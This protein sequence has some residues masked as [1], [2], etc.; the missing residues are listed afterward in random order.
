MN[1]ERILTEEE[2]YS[3]IRL[4]KEEENVSLQIKKSEY[5]KKA[6]IIKSKFDIRKENIELKIKH[7]KAFDKFEKEIKKYSCMSLTK[8]F[9][10]RDIQFSS[11]G[12][13]YKIYAKDLIEA[14]EKNDIVKSLK[15]MDA[16]NNIAEVFYNVLT[17]KNKNE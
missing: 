16:Y 12:T 2:K 1:I 8:I 11:L 7:R 9:I 3:N 15:E 17:T 5:E 13:K 10:N 6:S 4:V 14:F